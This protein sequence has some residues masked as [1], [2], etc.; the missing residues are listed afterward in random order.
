MVVGDPPVLPIPLW[1][2]LLHLIIII[3]YASKFDC[4]V[5]YCI[6]LFSIQSFDERSW[7]HV[8]IT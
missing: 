3:N 6:N 8:Q 4:L 5:V 7:L 1:A 2:K